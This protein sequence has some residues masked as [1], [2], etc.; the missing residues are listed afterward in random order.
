[1]TIDFIASSE[2]LP[3]T[4][5]RRI[6]CN[7]RIIVFYSSTDQ[8]KTDNIIHTFIRSFLWERWRSNDDCVSLIL[9]DLLIIFCWIHVSSKPSTL[10]Y[11]FLWS[12]FFSILSQRLAGIICIRTK[13]IFGSCSPTVFLFGSN[14][15]ILSSCDET[16]RWMVI[17]SSETT[18][19]WANFVRRILY[20][21]SNRK[22]SYMKEVFWIMTYRVKR[23]VIM[24]CCRKFKPQHERWLMK[25]DIFVYIDDTISKVLSNFFF[26]RL[27]KKPRDLCFIGH[28]A[29]HC[30]LAICVQHMKAND[31]IACMLPRTINSMEFEIVTF[32]LERPRCITCATIYYLL[33]G[34]AVIFNMKSC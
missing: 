15:S 20:P 10:R 14:L 16:G 13:K 7:R 9:D 28:S 21:I 19:V 4:I 24:E 23:R 3:S 33:S 29:A 1:M 27:S 34:S 31:N 18:T 25:E 2:A 22:D 11:S 6:S 8:M 30:F 12:Y 26:R 17:P 5:Y 32:F